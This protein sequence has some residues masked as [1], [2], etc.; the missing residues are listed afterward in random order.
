MPK[1]LSLLFPTLV[2]VITYFIVHK[3]FS[4]SKEDLLKD[5]RGREG[6][7]VEVVKETLV[8][9]LLKGG[10]LKVA[11]ISVFIIYIVT[12]FKNEIYTLLTDNFFKVLSKKKNQGQLKI[13]CDMVKEY[14]LDLHSQDMSE[15]L[16]A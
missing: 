1:L 5:F 13:V 12:N 4:K 8:Q 16:V 9:R 14:K 3:L 15:I 6:V 7:I 11:L 10:L 2:G